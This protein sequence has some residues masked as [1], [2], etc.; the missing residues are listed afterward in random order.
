MADF[1]SGSRQGALGRQLGRYRAKRGSFE[2]GL[3]PAAYGTS[4]GHVSHID[5]P[6]ASLSSI[7]FTRDSTRFDQIGSPSSGSCSGH[8]A[9]AAH[10]TFHLVG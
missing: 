5:I 4:E 2:S 7:K 3:D 1:E 6:I 8:R 10:K 9:L